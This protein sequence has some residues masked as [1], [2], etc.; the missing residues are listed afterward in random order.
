MNS[1]DIHFLMWIVSL[2]HVLYTNMYTWTCHSQNAFLY[3]FLL[4]EVCFCCHPQNYSS[5]ASWFPPVNGRTADHNVSINLQKKSSKKAI[6]EI[7]DDALILPAHIYVQ[8]LSV[9]CTWH[10]TCCFPP[11]EAVG[12]ALGPF[13]SLF[14]FT[15]SDLVVL[16]WHQKVRKTHKMPTM[17]PRSNGR[18]IG[19]TT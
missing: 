2:G 4:K 7:C 17:H 18:K 1:F 8:S 14:C 13:S 11:Y 9:M 3:P 6:S 19:T 15:F 10:L 5:I 16:V 12:R